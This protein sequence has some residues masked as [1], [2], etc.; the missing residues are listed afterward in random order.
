[1]HI[2]Q[3][4][5]RAAQ[6]IPSCAVGKVPL[7]ELEKIS[8]PERVDEKIESLVC[9]DHGAH[10]RATLQRLLQVR[11]IFEISLDHIF[12]N[13]L[14]CS[15]AAEVNLGGVKI[16]LLCR[17]WRDIRLAGAFSFLLVSPGSCKFDRNPHG[18]QSQ[19]QG[20]LLLDSKC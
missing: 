5:Q 13:I 11:L 15:I 2:S 10:I 7:A 12:H 19:V 17:T 8:G 14:P 3:T 4:A 18:W 6:D 9:I 16:D 20:V 1:M